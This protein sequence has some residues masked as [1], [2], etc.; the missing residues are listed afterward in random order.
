MTATPPAPPGHLSAPSARLWRQLTADYEL[1]ADELELLR[2]ALEA[3]DRA[4]QARRAIRRHG[5]TYADRFGAPHS[6]PEVKIERDSS[7]AAA[8]LFGQLQ[9]P[10]PSAVPE[11]PTAPARLRRA[12]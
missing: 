4:S 2:L 5:T 7:T 6:R 1:R 11:A 12:V 8:R 9:L 10:E 3:L